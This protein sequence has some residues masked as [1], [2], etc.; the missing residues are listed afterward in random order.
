MI[1]RLA[2]VT[3]ACLALATAS[4][5][6]AEDAGPAPQQSSAFSAGQ[7]EALH[8]EIRAY[9]LANPE[10]IMEM[11]KILDEKQ[12]VATATDDRTLVAAN[13]AAIF[14]DG[15]SWVGGNPDGK[16]TIVEFLDY[17]CGFCR[18]A[19]PEI[20]QLLEEN[21]DVRLIVKEMPIL[22]PG[23][24]LAAR[25]AV[26]TLVAEGPE[27]YGRLHHILMTTKGQITDAGLDRAFADAGVD[28]D[29]ARA[30]MEDPEVTRRLDATRALAET[31]GISGTPTFVVADTM[32][33]GYIPLAQMQGLL[34]TARAAE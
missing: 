15:F 14:D 2:Q 24:D 18:K 23:S 4:A 6:L 30:A 34:D 17:Q 20:T 3:A 21:D 25:A 33:R 26:A 22:G 1:R 19:Q 32:V 11:V 5:A 9:L 12:Q 28:A 27:A 13:A 16:V 31:L 8:A 7:I 29:K 10:I